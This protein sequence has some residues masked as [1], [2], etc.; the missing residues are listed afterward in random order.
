MRIQAQQRAWRQTHPGYMARKARDWRERQREYVRKWKRERAREQAVVTK[1]LPGN[2]TRGHRRGFIGLIEAFGCEPA[3][4]IGYMLDLQT[5]H[6]RGDYLKS[7]PDDFGA[8]QRNAH[9]A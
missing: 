2:L 9:A 1:P 3:A 8:P 5:T 4:F 7:I 6:E